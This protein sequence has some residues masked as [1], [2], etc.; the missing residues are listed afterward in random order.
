[1][2]SWVI[3]RTMLQK[4]VQTFFSN[5]DVLWDNR[6]VINLQKF[7]SSRKHTFSSTLGCGCSNIFVQIWRKKTWECSM[8]Y[9]WQIYIWIFEYIR[10]T[11]FRFCQEMNI[12]SPT[13]GRDEL[14]IT[15]LSIH[16]PPLTKKRAEEWEDRGDKTQ[17]YF[18][19]LTSLWVGEGV[20]RFPIWLESLPEKR[21][22]DPD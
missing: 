3:D 7:F 20:V 6:V 9:L 14:D 18:L 5:D 4:P 2:V 15:F 1:M 13:V 21:V 22:G 8:E 10:Q 16:L 11:L 17:R 12:F 19:F